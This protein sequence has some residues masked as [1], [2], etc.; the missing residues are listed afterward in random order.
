MIKA[1]PVLRNLSNINTAPIEIQMSKAKRV[2][3]VSKTSSNKIAPKCL[4]SLLLTRM[5]TT[6]EKNAVNNPSA[7]L[8]NIHLEIVEANEKKSAKTNPSS[9]LFDD[10]EISNT[11]SIRIKSDIAGTASIPVIPKRATKGILSSGY[12]YLSL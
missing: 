2:N 10:F 4:N 11:M 1:T 6:N 3:E 5:N 12:K 7:V 8:T 9:G